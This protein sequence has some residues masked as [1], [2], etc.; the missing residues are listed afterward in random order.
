[1]VYLF[2]CV[3]NC[4]Y[5]SLLHWAFEAL[6]LR[7]DTVGTGDFG[8]PSGVVFVVKLKRFFATPIKNPLSLS[9]FFYLLLLL[10]LH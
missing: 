2:L 1:M 10:S 4:L 9:G 5:R 6:A 8:L 7:M 3:L